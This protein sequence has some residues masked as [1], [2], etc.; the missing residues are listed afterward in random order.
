MP[1]QVPV[2]NTRAPSERSAA[3]ASGWG[4]SKALRRPADTSARSGRS[5]PTQAGP[6]A[7]RLP[8]WPAF[9]RRNRGP[10]PGSPRASRARSWMAS[11]SPMSQ[12]SR[13]R[14]RTRSTAEIML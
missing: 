6:E 11:A 7:L 5:A 2:T 12:I 14:Q 3:M 8:W 13:S 9:S 1:R 10:S 4:W